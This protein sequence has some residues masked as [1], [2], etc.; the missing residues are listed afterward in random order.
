MSKLKLV[1]RAVLASAA[2]LAVVLMLAV[3]V[4]F[5]AEAL[6]IQ[7]PSSVAFQLRQ[8]PPP[9][10]PSTLVIPEGTMHVASQIVKQ[11]L[12]KQVNPVY[13][14]EAKAARMQ[15]QVVLEVLIGTNGLVEAIG[16]LSGPPLL[17]QAA[18]DAVSQWEYKPFLLN[19]QP[20]RV[21]TTVEINFALN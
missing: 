14:P 12:L 4:P 10:T 3:F 19:G 1:T 17:T 21:V 11:S 6:V 13:P 7:Q 5:Q 16:L 9:P 20:T 2:I 15:S 8:P 18:I